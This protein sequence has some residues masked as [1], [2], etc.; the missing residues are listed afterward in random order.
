MKLTQTIKE[1]FSV[2]G[3][4]SGVSSIPDPIDTG[5][6]KRAQDKDGGDKTA[7]KVA[8]V[9]PENGGG[10]AEG[11]RASVAAK[12]NPTSVKTQAME[13]VNKI[14][15]MFAGQELSEE[16]MEKASVVFE[17]AVSELVASQRTALEE[18]Y[19]TKLEE[20]VKTIREETDTQLDEYLNYV[21][22]KWME[23]NKV[24]IESSLRGEV[25]ESFMQGLQK[26]FVEHNVNIPEDKAD[27]VEELI[28]KVEELEGKLNETINENIE[29]KKVKEAVDL[30]SVVEGLQADMTDTQKE[31]FGMLIE[32]VS[33]TSKEDFEKKAKII[34]EQYIGGTADTKKVATLTETVEK[35][36]PI[37]EAAAAAA[38]LD[39]NM[40]RYVKSIARN[41]IK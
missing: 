17:A 6:T 25:T 31:K 35:S 4:A 30:E 16:F 21:V 34:K 39:P 22:E 18:E 41:T 8:D 1:G 14:K 20:A 26:L 3:G 38:A 27:I 15:E 40:A 33:F 32:N 29:L 5:A 28:S 11:N 13:N 23:E 7:A 36:E 2:G 24:A 9:T 37:E 10:T 19:T 12:G